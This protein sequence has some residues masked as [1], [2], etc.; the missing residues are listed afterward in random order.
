MIFLGDD[1]FCYAKF[2]TVIHIYSFQY[3]KCVF[4]ELEILWNLLF[5]LFKKLGFWIFLV[6]NFTVCSSIIVLCILLVR[7]FQIWCLTLKKQMMGYDKK[8]MK[9]SC[10]TVF[11]RFGKKICMK[12]PSIPLAKTMIAHWDC[13]QQLL[14]VFKQFAWLKKKI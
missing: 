14:V 7:A 8:I 5:S 11:Y 4:F 12:E 9:K 10:K 6:E 3:E 2:F 1:V 13:I